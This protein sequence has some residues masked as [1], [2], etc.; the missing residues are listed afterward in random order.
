[1]T[2]ST[3]EQTIFLKKKELSHQLRDHFCTNETHGGETS[4]QAEL[5]LNDKMFCMSGQLRMYLSILTKPNA[6]VVTLR[7]AR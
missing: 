2:K 6:W 3:S 7:K 5:K 4:E 1:M